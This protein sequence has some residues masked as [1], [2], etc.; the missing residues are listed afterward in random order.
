MH[1]SHGWSG[2]G[3]ACKIIVVTKEPSLSILGVIT[4]HNVIILSRRREVCASTNKKRKAGDGLAP[5]KGTTGS[6]FIQFIKQVLTNIEAHDLRYWY[7]VIDN[8]AIHRTIDVKDW[9][10]EHGWEIIYL[11]TYSPFL[12]S[13]EGFGSKVNDVVNKNPVSV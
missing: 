12:N 6:D 1:R 2:I 7:L 10:T 3:K 4:A 8:V 13:I 11:P 9:V 5:K